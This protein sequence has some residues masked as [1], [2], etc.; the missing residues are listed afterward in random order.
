MP[1]PNIKRNDLEE[2]DRIIC[3]NHRVRAVGFWHDVE[4]ADKIK[5]YRAE[6][7]EVLVVWNPHVRRASAYVR[8]SEYQL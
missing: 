3:R 5:L 4:T 6:G 7:K 2:V 8:K 1:R